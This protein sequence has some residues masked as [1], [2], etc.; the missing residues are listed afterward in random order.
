MNLDELAR[1]FRSISDEPLLNELAQ[2]LEAWKT[3]DRNVKELETTVERLFGNTWL[4][5]E[6][7]HAKAYG[8]WKAFRDEVIRGIGGMTMNERLYFFGLFERF[9]SSNTERE[10]HAIYSKLL[11]NP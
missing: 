7:I 4:P 2:C 10:K 1:A 6:E 11:A 9:D 5:G 8:F 3:D